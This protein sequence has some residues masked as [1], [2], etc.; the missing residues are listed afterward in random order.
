MKVYVARD[1][2]GELTIFSHK[3][4]RCVDPGWNNG[5]WDN[6]NEESEFIDTLVI[7]PKLFPE[8]TWES[9]PKEFELVPVNDEDKDLVSLDKVCS[10][11]EENL[12]KETFIIN[13]GHV[14]MKFN[15]AI[16]KLRNDM[17]KR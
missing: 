14:L 13:S 16:E 8:I 2:D 4:Q 5:S 3:P 17:M 9:E 1:K 12:V 6:L 11:L 15:G 7:D 10:W